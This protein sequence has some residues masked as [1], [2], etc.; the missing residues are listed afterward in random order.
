VGKTTTPLTMEPIQLTTRPSTELR[1]LPTILPTLE[2]SRTLLMT[3][4]ITEFQLLLIMALR[5]FSR[6]VRHG[7][8]FYC[9]PRIILKLFGLGEVFGFLFRHL[10]VKRFVR[11]IEVF[12]DLCYIRVLKG[13][14]MMFNFQSGRSSFYTYLVLTKCG[15]LNQ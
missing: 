11:C 1:T 13:M 6:F 12:C 15:N 7:K 3:Q 4:F 9:L 14:E 10:H 5:T 2:L 8:V